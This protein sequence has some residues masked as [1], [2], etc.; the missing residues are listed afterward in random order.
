MVCSVS[1]MISTVFIIGMIYFYN[2]ANKSVVVQ[3]YRSQLSMPLREIYDKIA[4]ERAHISIKGYIL[5]FI[6]SLFIIFYNYKMKRLNSI[7][8]VCTVL[9]TS[10]LT[11]YFF[12]MLSPKTDW[13]LNHVEGP[14]QTRNWLEMYRSMQYYYHAGLFL[15][16][17]GVGIL[18]FAFR[19]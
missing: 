9:A 8:L 11:N 10:F 3:H 6:L 19:C 16:I 17:F 7:S 13:M 14:T 12:Y 1:C 5:G 18:A 2:A 4:K 15:G